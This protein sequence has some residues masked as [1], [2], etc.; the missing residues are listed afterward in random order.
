[1]EST[2]HPGR[3]ELGRSGDRLFGR[4]PFELD[5]R[6]EDQLDAMLRLTDELLARVDGLDDLD[7]LESLIESQPERWPW[8]ARVIVKLARSKRVLTRRPGPLHLSVVVPL[9]AEHERIRRPQESEV[10]EGFLIEDVGR[11]ANRMGR[12]RI[13]LPEIAIADLDQRYATEVA[14]FN[15]LI[16][17]NS[18]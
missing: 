13:N 9:Y 1:M 2:D 12:Q 5:L 4:L 15:Y 8:A 11:A 17:N 10:G 16:G 6:D 18:K 7:A 14:I 3:A